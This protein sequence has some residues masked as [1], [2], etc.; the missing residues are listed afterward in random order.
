MASNNEKNNVQGKKKS[1][2]TIIAIVVGA[3]V[4]LSVVFAYLYQEFVDQAEKEKETEK[5]EKEVQDMLEDNQQG[6]PL[7]IEKVKEYNVTGTYASQGDISYDQD[8]WYFSTI[9]LSISQTDG[10]EQLTARA[11]TAYDGTAKNGWW[12]CKE[13]DGIPFIVLAVEGKESPVTYQVYNSYI[14]DTSSAYNGY[15]ADD[16]YFDSVFVMSDDKA[17]MQITLSSDG[18]ASAEFVDTNPESENN[19][20]T[21]AMSGKYTVN[22]DYLDITLNGSTS[23]FLKF[24]FQTSENA[25]VSGIASVFFLKQ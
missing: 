7:L 25:E 17:S 5:V 11:V 19:G 3:L 6:A 13:Y 4:I 24:K 16:G 14:F 20:T 23:R 12:V 15:V 10:R 22:G 2:R 9:D 21:Y 1:M 8:S 18:S